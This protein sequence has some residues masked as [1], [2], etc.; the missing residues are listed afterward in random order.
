MLF[1]TETHSKLKCIILFFALMCFALPVAAQESGD[2][3]G[4][5]GGDG[6]DPPAPTNILEEHITIPKPGEPTDPN[7]PD[8]EVGEP[9]VSFE[10][11]AADVIAEYRTRGAVVDNTDNGKLTITGYAKFQRNDS[12]GGGGGVF[13]LDNSTTLIQ[14]EAEFKENKSGGNAGAIYNLNLAKITMEDTALFEKNIAHSS[15]G[16]IFNEATIIFL[17]DVTFTEN[18]AYAQGGAIYNNSTV[19]NDFKGNIE[20]SGNTADQEGGAIYNQSGTFTFLAEKTATFSKNVSALAGGAIYHNGGNF[21]FNGETTFSE[22]TSSATG[23]AIYNNA[24][25]SLVG[26]TSFTGNQAG[27]G[28]AVHNLSSIGFSNETTFTENKAN[29]DGGAIY[30]T[31]SIVLGSNLNFTSNTAG[32]NGGA[33]WTNQNLSLTNITFSKNT[34]GEGGGAIYSGGG[35]LS[36]GQGATFTN[37]SAKNGG[38]IYRTGTLTILGGS[39]F[40]NNSA[41]AA[42]GAIYSTGTINVQTG[43]YQVVFKNNFANDIANDIH[44]SG[45]S[46]LLNVTSN[47]Q[48]TLNSGITVD[49]GKLSNEST[50]IVNGSSSSF[51]NATAGAIYNVGKL[52]LGGLFSTNANNASHGGAIF[53]GIGATLTINSGSTFD[54]NLVSSVD[55]ERRGGAILNRGTLNFIGT[56]SFNDNVTS[57]YA[58][59]DGGAIANE[60][61]IDFGGVVY[62]NR[63]QSQH[64]AGAIFNTYISNVITFN[65]LSYFTDN[66][67]QSG[68]AI[69]NQYGTM[70]FKKNSTFRGNHG[71]LNGGAILN[72]GALNFELM[73]TFESNYIDTTTSTAQGGAIYNYGTDTV[74]NFKSIS[75]IKGNYVKSTSSIAKGGGVYNSAKLLFTR[76]ANFSANYASSDTADALGG[77]F[78][79]DNGLEVSFSGASATFSNNKAISGTASAKGGAIYNTSS[80]SYQITFSTTSTTFSGNSANSTDS[81]AMGGAIYN[82]TSGVMVFEKSAS[83]SG[84]SANSTNASSLGGAVYNTG[85]LSFLAS[86]TFTSNSADFGGAIYNNGNLTIAGGGRFRQ[87]TASFAGGAVYVTAGKTLELKPSTNAELLFENNTAAG[88]ANDIYLETGATLNISGA[89]TV[90]ILSGISG[91]MAG[92]NINVNDTATLNI[93]TSTFDASSANVRFYGGTTL[94]VEVASLSNYGVFKADTLTITGADI[95]FTIVPDLPDDSIFYVLDTVNPVIGNFSIAKNNF[96]RIVSVGNGGYQITILPEYAIHR[97]LTKAGANQNHLNVVDAIIAADKNTGHEKFDDLTSG[98]FALLQNDAKTGMKAL[99]QMMPNINQLS[100]AV[101]L[102]LHH[103]MF[104]TISNR[105]TMIANYDPNFDYIWPWARTFYSTLSH[106]EGKNSLGFD[107]SIMGVNA[108]IDMKTSAD[109]TV[110]L[111]YTYGMPDFESQG[112]DFS[113]HSHN[114][115]VYANY[116]PT[117]MYLTL[118]ASGSFTSYEMSGK[119]L[120][121]SN[122]AKYDV[123]AASAAMR[124]GY[125]GDGLYVSPYMQVLYSYMAQDEYSD[126]IGQTIK[127]INRNILSADV[128]MVYDYTFRLSRTFLITPK[129][130]AALTYDIIPG[131][132]DANVAMHDGTSYR[133]VGEKVPA[134]GLK[135]GAQ[136]EV[137]LPSGLDMLFGYNAEMK[138]KYTAHTVSLMGQ[139]KL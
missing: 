96:Y 106:K 2:G 99:N 3:D 129:L 64:T 27:S 105:L 6:G 33:I 114:I 122:S 38:A 46:A 13:Y 47:G 16:A 73:G 137:S 119:V 116:A 127:S 4:G 22:N 70:H 101:T 118:M 17:S 62:F 135:G 128:G 109:F 113:A 54:G 76:E 28:G 57:G 14:G 50:T 104:D 125:N 36:I 18:Q 8:S 123:Y 63:N 9:T 19:A 30:N 59:N 66:L 81:S 15:G 45:S 67:S 111:A 85:S 23:G 43:E 71:S 83:F 139:I 92:Y 34:A 124:V 29:V 82:D 5:D 39:T 32:G 24:T 112:N 117:D 58:E 21:T 87:N 26:V 90:S 72:S 31:G 78:Y 25:I 136:L 1:N 48:L 56:A 55:T 69:F 108:G 107:G 131:K 51:K 98:F 130:L 7:D 103:N 93:G 20:F 77:A 79:N 68:G 35:T 89:G 133:L 100:T 80:A 132:M 37:N 91:N 10:F 97:N 134:F 61:Q 75:N 102:N 121:V 52:T 94:M 42:G 44:L 12:G 138:G 84:N 74:I 40:Q 11:D 65:E 88:L 126:A 110:G 41:T 120:G 53:N 49:G 86:T 115:S 60:S 95:A